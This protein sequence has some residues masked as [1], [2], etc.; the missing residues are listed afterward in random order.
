MKKPIKTLKTGSI[1]T[2]IRE[3][4]FLY[5][6]HCRDSQFRCS[7]AGIRQALRRAAGGNLA[8]L[9]LIR[10]PGAPDHLYVRPCVDVQVRKTGG[11]AVGCHLFSPRASLILAKWANGARI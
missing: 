8:Q 1:G 10:L 5:D 9:A 3:D 7:R 11:F 6:N 2:K 4:F